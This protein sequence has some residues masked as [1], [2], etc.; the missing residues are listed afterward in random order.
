MIQINNPIVNTPLVND[1]LSKE[2]RFENQC[3]GMI[4]YLMVKYAVQE[5]LD[6]ETY[7]RAA[8][9]KI[10]RDNSKGFSNAY[11]NLPDFVYNFMSEGLISQFRPE[12][13]EMT[14]DFARVDFHYCPMLGGLCNMTDDREELDLLCDC[15]MET[16]RGLTSQIGIGFELGGT[17]AKGNDTCELCFKWRK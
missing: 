10:G 8:I 5:G 16:D 14:D 13:K 11:D 2:V 17:I 12:L 6:K 1:R 3:R 15:A 4:Y 7:A 9:N